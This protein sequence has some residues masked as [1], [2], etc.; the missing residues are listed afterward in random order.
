MRWLQRLTT[1]AVLGGLAGGAG[2]LAYARVRGESAQS[3]FDTYALFRDGSG[4]PIGSKVVIAGVKVGEGAAL[5]IEGDRARID[6][7]L[8]GDVALYTDAWAIK[9]ASSLLGDNYLELLPGGPGQ[10]PAAGSAGGPVASTTRLVSGQPIPQV[11]ESSSTDRLLRTVAAAVPQVAEATARGAEFVARARAEVAGGLD[12]RLQRADGWLRDHPDGFLGRVTPRVDRADEWLAE[13]DDHTTGLAAT[14]NKRLD[15][16][17]ADL[18]RARTRLA[19]AQGE[20]RDGFAGVRAG[21]DGVDPYID[22]AVAALDEY[23]EPPAGGGADGEG[24]GTLA[25]LIHDDALGERLH[26]LARSGADFTSSLDRFRSW[27]GFRAE[28]NLGAG[29]PRFYVVADLGVRGD[30]FYLIELEKGGLGGV[31]ETTLA[32]RPGSDAFDRR[33]TIR[34]EVRFTAQFGKRFGPW[35][36]RAGIKE[37]YFGAGTDLDVLGG[38]LRVSADLFESAFS[39]T[40]RLKLGGALLLFRQIYVVAGVDDVIT[41]PGALPIG[42]WPVDQDVPIQFLELRYG[43]DYYA[44]AMLSL[45]D[46]DLAAILRVYGA[47]IVGLL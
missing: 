34:E 13:A 21:L 42:P 40:P 2:W 9:R 18:T 26:D 29:Q 1:V 37:S 8:R 43:R 19:E 36:I 3:G 16:F 41:T 12:D 27:I 28:Y 15:Q 25:G 22:R 38:R 17:A 5:T 44:G 39:R 11:V 10:G 32:D 35:R 7:R 33:V 24:G 4:L 23:A 45:T 30:K 31:P 20:V 14:V 46:A 6:L 47:L